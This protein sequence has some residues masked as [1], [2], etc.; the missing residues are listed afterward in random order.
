MFSLKSG[1]FARVLP[2]FLLYGLIFCW[3]SLGDAVA[4][5]LF[6]SRVGAA[7]LPPFYGITAGINLVLIAAYL[8]FVQQWPTVR[9]FQ[10]VVAGSV[11]VFLGCWF[12]LN[13]Q[14][15]DS[16]AYGVLFVAREVVFTF[17]LMH[18]GTFLG[19]FFSRDE[20]NRLVPFIYTGGRLGGI[21]GGLLVGL[22]SRWLSVL[23][24]LPVFAVTGLLISFALVL[25][26]RCRPINIQEPSVDTLD[27]KPAL[28]E[29][30][31]YAYNSALLQW[32]CG[33]VFLFI[34]CKW[35][36]NFQANT[37]FE[38]TFSSAQALA[39]YL[40]WY[41]AIALALAM[42]I[43]LCI[44]PW[45]VHRAGAATGYHLYNL[46]LM[47]VLGCYL[48]P[49][50]SGTGLLVLATL[51][52]FL[53]VELRLGFRNPLTLLM[54]NAFP[55]QHRARSR[56]LTMG[57]VIP[58]GTFVASLLLLAMQHYWLAGLV[59]LGLLLGIVNVWVSGHL[60]CW[61]S[62]EDARG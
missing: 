11:L 6:V 15:V 27:T 13:V 34:L 54:T 40:G 25:I 20:L 37:V 10:W 5:S 21:L 60:R 19:D 17:V 30:C 28:K 47:G 51:S 12:W 9:L 53:E 62:R 44:V 36:L 23:Q 59:W 39:G 43:Q 22:L 42:V 35:L 31:G 45:L 49:L 57:L 26:E 18:F 8:I 41:T 55:W 7:A 1:D 33:S 16:S 32:F 4:V 29:F 50:M 46:L 52:R 48:L 14:A 2:F 3:L 61:M 24:F 38:Q 56:A 58:I